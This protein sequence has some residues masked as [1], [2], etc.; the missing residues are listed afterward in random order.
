MES[1]NGP[2]IDAQFGETYLRY[3]AFAKPDPQFEL[4][5]FNFD[6]D[7]D[8]LGAAARMMDATD[9]DLSRFQ[10]RG[11][12]IVMYFGWADPALAPEMGVDYYEKVEKQMGASTGDFMR[13]FMVPGMFHC[14][15]GVGTSVFDA[16]TPL[17]NWVEAGNAPERI[18][19]SRVVAGKVVRTRP[20]CSY[21]EVAR[22][23]GNGSIDESANFTCA[24]P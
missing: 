3:M 9:A 10:A 1:R 7:I 4:M 20:L 8:E 11:G 16:A 17:V 15:G 21:P 18:E 6:T 23:T 5:K 2:T 13:L 22:Y 12:K 14:G 19:A 24:K